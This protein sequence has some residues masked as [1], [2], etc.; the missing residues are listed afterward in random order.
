MDPTHPRSKPWRRTGAVLAAGAVAVGLSACNPTPTPTPR[1]GT[2]IP[3]LVNGEIHYTDQEIIT[4]DK[5]LGVNVER[6]A[7]VVGKPLSSAVGTFKAA[8]IDSQLTAKAGQVL[9]TDAERAAYGRD[10]DAL[11]S[12]YH[13]PLLSIENEET[14]DQFYA[15]TPD[16]YL[17]ELRIATKVA[18]AHHVTVTDGGIPW[19][20]VSLVTWD[21][22]R[23]TK[24]TATADAFLKTV[25]REPTW[26]WIVRDLGGVSKTDPDPY[27]HLG[28]PEMAQSWRDAHYLLT[29]FGTDPGDVPIDYVNFHWYVPDEVGGYRTTGYTDAQALRDAVAAIQALTDGKQVVSNEV[30]QRGTTPEAVVGTL[31]VLVYEVKAPFVIWFDADGIPARALHDAPGDLRTNGIAFKRFL[32]N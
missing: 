31:H 22:V 28:R 8:G 19:P 27:G 3:N 12:E 32:R 30:G 9:D 25:F 11:L 13:T 4:E 10:L 1:V 16:E 5:A 2:F 26:A 17:S 24:G 21:H 29:K 20:I 6:V 23:T 7:Q 15:G 18:K 14:V